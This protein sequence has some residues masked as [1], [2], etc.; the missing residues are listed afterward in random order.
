[1]S[2][3]NIRRALAARLAGFT[4]S[5]PL[6]VAPAILWLTSGQAVGSAEG[7]MAE[8]ADGYWIEARF[9][10]QTTG[11]AGYTGDQTDNAGL[12]RLTAV[13]RKSETA[14][15]NVITLSDQIAAHFYKGLQLFQG[16]SAVKIDRDTD[17]PS[18]FIENGR[19]KRPVIVRWRSIG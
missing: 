18:E 12:L 10:G 11:R 8:P 15:F 6:T 9:Q 19:I 13:E 5:S 4:V 2:D 3:I 16:G 7:D 17:K 1:M 14:E